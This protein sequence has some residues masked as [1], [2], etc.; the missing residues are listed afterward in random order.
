MRDAVV[1]SES[2]VV[3][4][5]REDAYDGT[6]SCPLPE[7]FKKWYGPFPPIKSVTHHS[8]APWGTVGD[9]RTLKLTGPGSVLETQRIDEK[10]TRFGYTLTDVKG[11]MAMLVS[12]IEGEWSFAD[13]GAGTRITWQWSI[14]P[15]SA[16][17]GALIPALGRMWRGYA[18]QSL[19][20][21]SGY[22]QSR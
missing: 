6:L 21:L 10:P 17:V 18:R 5:P 9:S 20:T 22:L 19:N 7:V 8:T 16:P 12:H 13:A 14:H 1:V 4:L 15:K 11:P 3:P 2:I